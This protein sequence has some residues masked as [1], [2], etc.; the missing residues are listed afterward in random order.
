MASPP[1]QQPIPP[2]GRPRQGFRTA[3]APAPSS[4]WPRARPSGL[5]AAPRCALRPSAR[6]WPRPAV[7]WPCAPAR[8]RQ[9]PHSPALGCVV[10]VCACPRQAVVGPVCACQRQAMAPTRSLVSRWLPARTAAFAPDIAYQRVLL[11]QSMRPLAGERVF[12]RREP[13]RIIRFVTAHGKERA[14]SLRDYTL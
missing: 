2:V 1:F 12:R 10:A 3:A 6:S 4:P 5:C 8:A 13:K 14:L 9:W 7:P 11:R